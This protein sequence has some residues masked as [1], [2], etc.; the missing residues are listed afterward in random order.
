[1]RLENIEMNLE[2][3]GLKHDQN[4]SRLISILYYE[5]TKRFGCLERYSETDWDFYLI[6]SDKYLI[7]SLPEPSRA[8]IISLLSDTGYQPAIAYQ[9]SGRI[10]NI[11]TSM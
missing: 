9:R 11:L 7:P 6:Q 2:C 8:E 10:K 4:S 5:G 3:I 1:M